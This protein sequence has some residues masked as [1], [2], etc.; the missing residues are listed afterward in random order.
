MFIPPMEREPIIPTPS[1]NNLTLDC[2]ITY[3]RDYLGFF[4]FPQDQTLDA[5]RDAELKNKRIGAELSQEQRMGMPLPRYRGRS[6]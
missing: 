1:G 2:Y 3:V 5:L 4:K 6:A